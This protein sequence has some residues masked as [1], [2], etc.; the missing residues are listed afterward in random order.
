MPNEPTQCKGKPK[1]KKVKKP[2]ATTN[3]NIDD[4]GCS[5]GYVWDDVL[6]KCK[7]DVG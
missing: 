3:G 4:H 7:L 5:E 6:K 1:G 2:I